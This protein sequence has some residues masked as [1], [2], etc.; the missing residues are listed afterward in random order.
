MAS[1]TCLGLPASVGDRLLGDVSVH[2]EELGLT[3]SGG[4]RGRAHNGSV[5]LCVGEA[6]LREETRRRAFLKCRCKIWEVDEIEVTS[7]IGRTVSTY[8]RGETAPAA[9]I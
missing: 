6:A 7:G 3:L 2:L 9:S 5:R 4:S 8:C 1:P